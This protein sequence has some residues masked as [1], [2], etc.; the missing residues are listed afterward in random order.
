MDCHYGRGEGIFMKHSIAKSI[1]IFILII[2]LLFTGVMI[3]FTVKNASEDAY[4]HSQVKAS[5]AAEAVSSLYSGIDKRVLIENEAVRNSI[6][7]TMQAFLDENELFLLYIVI[8]DTEKSTID[9]LFIVGTNEAQEIVKDCRENPIQKRS[10]FSASMLNI[11]DG[12]SQREDL[13]LDNQFGHVISTYVPLRDQDQ[14]TIAVVGADVS[15]SMTRLSLMS[16]LPKKLLASFIIGFLSP[17]FLYFVLK[18]KII[19]PTLEISRAMQEFGKDGNYEA[20][21]LELHCDNELALI[22]D[23]FHS[24]ALNIQDNIARIKEYTQMQN[25]Q[26]YEMKAA[27]KIQQGFLPAA[28]YEEEGLQINACMHPAKNI[29]GDFYDY[30]DYNGQTIVVIADVSGKGL[31]G[32]IFMASAITLIRGFVKQFPDPHDVLTAVNEELEHTN[33]NMMFVTVFLAYI[34]REKS[35]IRYCNA[36]HNPP[37]LISDGRIKALT[38]SGGLPLGILVEEAY[39]TAEEILPLGATLFLYTDG[40]NEARNPSLDFFGMERLEALLRRSQ[41]GDR[42]ETIQKEL[43]DFRQGCEPYDDIT[44]LAFTSKAEELVLPAKVSCFAQL[45]SW[46]L[47]DEKIPEDIRKSLCLMAEEI[48]INISSYAY[49]KAEGDVTIRKQIQKDGTCFLQFTDQGMPFDPTRD[50]TDIDTYDPFCQIG[51][52]GRFMVDSLADAWHYI[53]MENSNILL[54]RKR[55]D[56]NAQG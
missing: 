51:G 37:Y 8:P 48:F 34:D 53:H 25:R 56:F 33:P 27:S 41:D 32:A 29:G 38:A 11:M 21:T 47:E 13:E 31:S 49:E 10:S 5:K 9:Y 14:N 16:S 54:I 23:S 26:E 18:K 50:I 2:S 36:G 17:L 24:M 3:F 28:H 12:S 39:E 46:I 6:Q 7:S 15:V 40:V 52:L 43:T 42:L 4:D 55:G 22:G 35:L 20:P 45:K 19:E 1:L 30:F 44:M